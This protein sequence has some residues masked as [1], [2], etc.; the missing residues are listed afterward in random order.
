MSIEYIQGIQTQVDNNEIVTQLRTA[1][2]EELIAVH[3]YWSQSKI[4]QGSLKDEIQKELFQHRDEEM[5][6]ANMLMD[7]ILQLGGNPELKPIDWDRF[8]SCRYTPNVNWDQRSILEVAIQGEK[9]S[10]EHYTQIA[11]FVEHRDVTTYD[12]IQKILD[13]EYEHIRDLK[14]LEEMLHDN[15]S[16]T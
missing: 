5:G 9:C 12:I 7:R 13:D 1:L 2:A 3:N 8:A 6:H 15:K 11:Q 16:N 4:I 10:T 14:K